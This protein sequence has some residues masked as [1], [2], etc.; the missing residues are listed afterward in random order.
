MIYVTNKEKQNKRRMKENWNNYFSV[1]RLPE[2]LIEI[3]TK[4]CSEIES[5]CSVELVDVFVSNVRK[6]SGEE[7][8][9]L[10]FFSSDEK[11]FECKNF[12]TD[13]DY[14]ILCLHKNVAYFNII[15]K[16]L[17]DVENPSNE[18]SMTVNCYIRGISMVCDFSATGVNCK[19]LVAI[20]KKYY[21]SNMSSEQ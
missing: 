12:I 17:D 14:D 10:W 8:K 5:L 19:Y 20:S 3:I 9:S 13:D 4:K 21:I 2:K 1:I 15:K 16:E 7:Y 6:E 11:A 18:S